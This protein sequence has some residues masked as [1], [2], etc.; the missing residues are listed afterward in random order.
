MAVF[1]SW[2]MLYFLFCVCFFFFFQFCSSSNNVFFWL[3]LSENFHSQYSS[4]G[5]RILG[6]KSFSFR[7]LK[8]LFQWPLTFTIAV[9]NSESIQ[10]SNLCDLFFFFNFKKHS[11]SFIPSA[12]K[13]HTDILW[14]GPI[15]PSTEYWVSSFSI[16]G[17]LILGNYLK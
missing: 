15:H 11:K 8:L 16:S 10:L 1:M 14:C 13:L 7:T 2:K 9:G 12:L 3:C 4:A 6:W 17:S 5:Y